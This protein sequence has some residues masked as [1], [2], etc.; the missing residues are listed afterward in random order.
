M[1]AMS[2]VTGKSRLP[3]YLG[4]APMKTASNLASRLWIS[5]CSSFDYTIAPFFRVTEGSDPKRIP[6]TYAPEITELKDCVTYR[7]VPQLMVNKPGD[8]L[9]FAE[10]LLKVTP[11]VDLN[12]GCAAPTSVSRGGGSS[13]IRSQAQF[14]SFLETLTER[15]EPGSMSVKMR[16]GFQDEQEM[17][18]LLDCMEGL[19]LAFVTIHGRTAAE[20]YR[21]RARWEAVETAA[22]RLKCPV[23]GSGDVFSWDSYR[24]FKEVAPSAQSVMI[25]R[26]SLRNPWVF[27]EIDQKEAVLVSF[28][29]LV[30][31]LSCFALMQALLHVDPKCFLK[32]ARKGLFLGRCGCSAK[33]WEKLFFSL[34]QASHGRF[35]DLEGWEPGQQGLSFV[36]MLWQRL[37]TSLPGKFLSPRPLRSRSFREFLMELERL[38]DQ[39]PAS[40]AQTYPLTHKPELS[41]LLAP[42]LDQS[43]MDGD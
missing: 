25:G 2:A 15:L 13:L 43:I 41:Q 38:H 28:E 39:V 23:I 4:L 7:L 11:V 10:H 6:A 31:A 21:G 9:R 29:C 30:H 27:Q 22:R 32:L 34:V 16:I 40:S 18:K 1:T 5:Q 8:F 24:S 19:S 37:A 12:C 14:R 33:A 20:N 26:G 3:G 17:P 36:K 35:V 42:Q